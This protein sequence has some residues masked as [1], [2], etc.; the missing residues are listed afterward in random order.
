MLTLTVNR[1][2]P[3]QKAPKTSKSAEETEIH[4]SSVDYCCIYYNTATLCVLLTTDICIGA[5][6]VH[7]FYQSLTLLLRAALTSGFLLW[8]LIKFYLICHPPSMTGIMEYRVEIGLRRTAA[9]SER[10]SFRPALPFVTERRATSE[11]KTLVISG[12][13]R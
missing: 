12:D 10:I 4:W 2:C 7:C 13:A 5:Y 11:A 8:G 3:I 6:N 9:I 1:T